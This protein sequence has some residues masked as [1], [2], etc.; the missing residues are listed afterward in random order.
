MNKI[1]AQSRHAHLRAGQVLIALL[2][3]PKGYVREG[4]STVSAATRIPMPMAYVC[5][6]AWPWS[7]PKTFSRP[8]ARLRAMSWRSVMGRSA[9]R[10]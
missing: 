1:S 3:H 4:P 10:V 6:L 9:G 8:Y 7:R 2:D 5:A